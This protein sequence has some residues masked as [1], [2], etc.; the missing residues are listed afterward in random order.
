MNKVKVKWFDSLNGL[1]EGRT[2]DNKK[3]FLKA[4]NITNKGIFKNLKEK[5][6]ILCLIV[7]KENN[8]YAKEI[9]KMKC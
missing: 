2:E 6:E 4:Q 7:K 8:L 9:R 1:G 5:E 3:V